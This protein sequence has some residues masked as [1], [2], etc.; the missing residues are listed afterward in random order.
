MVDIQTAN[1]GIYY[2][3]VSSSCGSQTSTPF[4]L[5]VN[6]PTHPDYN[7]LADLFYSTNG[8]GWVNRT[9]WLR[10]CDPCG[11]W[12]GVECTGGRATRLGL[13][14]NNMT[15]SIPETIA[16]LT[17]LTL[18]AIPYNP[19]SGT[20]PV[21]LSG[22]SELATLWIQNAQLT[23]TIP[24][25]YD[26]LRK[27]QVLNLSGNRLSGGIPTGLLSITGLT[28]FWL[29]GNQLSGDIPTSWSA[30]TNVSSIN[31]TSNPFTPGP[32]P[33]ELSRLPKLAN[34]FLADAN[35]TGY[36]PATFGT[37]TTLTHLSIND[38]QLSGCLP[39]SLTALCGRNIAISR[40]PGL[41]NNG[42]WAAFCA[43]GTGSYNGT[44]TT[45]KTGYWHDK[46]VWSCGAMP[47]AGDRAVVQHP[48]TVAPVQLNQ[49]GQV[50]LEGAGKL[51]YETG[52]LLKMGN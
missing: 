4:S 3:V 7:A 34:L 27:L 10:S 52:G 31:L 16:Q 32:I 38:N 13:L 43:N 50:R 5:T 36:I 39:S 47:Q 2:V 23:G 8:M 14:F 21:S 37:I 29:A 41:P 12:F 45:T 44:L 22:L 30:L 51:I 9:G 42:D 15:G 33:I 19:I 46:T 20:L 40:N 6:P 24:E 35:R 11:G 48:V 26:R 17:S 28:Q 49:A 1:A 18:L 25:G